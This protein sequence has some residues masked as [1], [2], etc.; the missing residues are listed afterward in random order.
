MNAS[1]SLRFAVTIAFWPDTMLDQFVSAI[2][3]KI[4]A[5]ALAQI[6]V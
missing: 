4:S 5:G 3:A 1:Q 2:I 6:V